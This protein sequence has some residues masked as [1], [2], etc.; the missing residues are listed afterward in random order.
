M[1]ECYEEKLF[2]IQ[3]KR[4]KNKCS[5]ILDVINKNNDNVKRKKSTKAQTMTVE[6]KKVKTIIKYPRKRKKQKIAE[7]NLKL[8]LST[9]FDFD[10]EEILDKFLL[11]NLKKRSEEK[12]FD[13]ILEKIPD[14]SSIYY[15]EH[16]EGTNACR[17]RKDP[18]QD[19]KDEL[20]TMLETVDRG[21]KRA[22]SKSKLSQL[23]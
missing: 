5:E 6:S 20:K 19:K 17:I 8:L 4:K 16:R 9:R 12:I 23:K 13:L 15:I 18:K 14:K 10:P 2:K 21:I 3:V 7:N 1:G 11:F 22:T